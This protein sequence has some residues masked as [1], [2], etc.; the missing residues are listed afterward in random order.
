MRHNVDSMHVGKGLPFF[1]TTLPGIV[2]TEENK[3]STGKIAGQVREE[4]FARTITKR[5]CESHT[6]RRRPLIN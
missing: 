4:V 1:T 2:K 5:L 3:K 6:K